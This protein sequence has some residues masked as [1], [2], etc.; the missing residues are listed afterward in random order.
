MSEYTTRPASACRWEAHRHH[1]DIQCLAGGEE[2]IGVVPAAR[3][4][5]GPFDADADV[6]W[7]SGSG[8]FLTLRPG[9]FVILW[10]G[11]AHMPGVEAGAPGLVRKVV[12]KVSL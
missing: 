5:R 10:P 11:D 12:V 8:D 6:A 4:E 3:L 9:Q 1:L 7:L 2:R